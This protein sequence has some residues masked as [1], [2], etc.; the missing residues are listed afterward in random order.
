[1]RREACMSSERSV[2]KVV[3]APGLELTAA[4][5]RSC[6]ERPNPSSLHGHA[7]CNDG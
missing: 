3:A 2:W 1:M 5:A 4:S 7:R 6:G